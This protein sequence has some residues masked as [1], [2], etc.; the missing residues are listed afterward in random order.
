MTGVRVE[1]LGRFDDFDAMQVIAQFT[2]VRPSLPILHPTAVESQASRASGKRAAWQVHWAAI[3]I[4]GL[5]GRHVKG[6][7]VR[8]LH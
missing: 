4:T 2:C 8:S 5:G 6:I 3:T 7:I 1:R